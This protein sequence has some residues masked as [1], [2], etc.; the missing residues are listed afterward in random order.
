MLDSMHSNMKAVQKLTPYFLRSI[1]ILSSRL[2]LNIPKRACAQCLTK[3]FLHVSTVYHVHYMPCPSRNRLNSVNANEYWLQKSSLCDIFQ[4]AI[5]SSLLGQSNP[6]RHMFS[7]ILSLVICTLMNTVRYQS[8]FTGTCIAIYIYV[9]L[10]FTLRWFSIR[11]CF[12]GFS[13]PDCK[14]Q[15]HD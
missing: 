10:Y 7:N 2:H 3:T 8:K 6:P 15:W 13:E 9:R 14:S 4:S 11:F 12:F 5:D 1:S